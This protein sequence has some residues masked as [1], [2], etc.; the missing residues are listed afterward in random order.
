MGDFGHPSLHTKKAYSWKQI[1]DQA[2]CKTVHLVNFSLKKKFTQVVLFRGVQVSNN[3]VGSEGGER[4]PALGVSWA[5][6]PHCRILLTHHRP[7]DA[8]LQP[9]NQQDTQRVA[10][11]IKSGRQVREDD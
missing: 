3:Q 10:R 7:G 9:A 1:S 5:H 8:N 11:I 4:K 6:V 2:S